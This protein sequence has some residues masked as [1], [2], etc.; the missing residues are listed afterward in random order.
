[1]SEV[2]TDAVIRTAS[3]GLSNDDLTKLLVAALLGAGFTFFLTTLKAAHDEQRALCD[4]LAQALLEAADIAAEYWLSDGRAPNV[5]L[6]EAK[7]MGAQAYLARYRVLAVTWFSPRDRWAVEDG[8]AQF[9]DQLSGGGFKVKNR[10]ADA[11][12]A[13]A[14]QVLAANLAVT[15]RQGNLNS[16]RVAARLVRAIGWHR[17][18]RQFSRLFQ[19]TEPRS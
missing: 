14:C 12:R 13:E 3:S 11:Q 10:P 7:M 6:L 19:W 5:P 2:A 4:R 17:F 16:L 1:L 8:M 18:K 15:I 9:Y